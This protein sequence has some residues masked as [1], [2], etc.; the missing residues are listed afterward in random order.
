[1]LR[2]CLLLFAL[3]CPGINHLSK[4]FFDLVIFQGRQVANWQARILS[5]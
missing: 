3:A 2:R 5:F 1:M 4:Q